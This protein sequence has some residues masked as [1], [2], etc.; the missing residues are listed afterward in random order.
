MPE[1]FEKLILHRGDDSIVGERWKRFKGVG[2][3]VGWMERRLGFL[4]MWAGIVFKE[5]RFGMGEI[6]KH[7]R[8]GL[9]GVE[10][11]VQRGMLNGKKVP[12]VAHPSTFK[13]L[14]GLG[15]RG[16]WGAILLKEAI[17]I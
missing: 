9:G 17:E 10:F 5:N 2:K 6:E 16:G 3:L 7:L 13:S 8:T 14:L 12:V 4:G 11:D 1:M 15:G